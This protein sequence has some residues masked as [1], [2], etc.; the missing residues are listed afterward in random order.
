MANVWE[1]SPDG[2]TTKYDITDLQGRDDIDGINLLKYPF[3]ST[4][5][6]GDSSII[7]DNKNG[8][9]TF[10]GTTTQ[11]TYQGLN[12]RNRDVGL[13]LP[14]GKYKATGC[15]SGGGNNSYYMGLY[16]TKN[17]ASYALGIDYGEGVEITINGDDFSSEGAYVSTNFYV[18]SGNTV[19]FTWKP[20]ITEAKYADIPY[21]PYNQQSIQHQI[22][23]VTGVTG[24]RNRLNLSGLTTQTLNGVTCTVTRDSKGNVTEVDLNGTATANSDFTISSYTQ[25]LFEEGEW[26]LSDVNGYRTNTTPRTG[27]YTYIARK[28]G[29]SGTDNYIQPTYAGEKKPFTVNYSEY[30]Y[31][32][33]GIFVLKNTT[34]NHFKL[35][36]MVKS[37]SDPDDTYV[38]F[39]MTNRELTEVVE[40]KVLA[41]A[42]ANQTWASQ[43]A[44]LKAVWDTYS[45]VQKMRLCLLHEGYVIWYPNNTSVFGFN[46]YASDASGFDMYVVRAVG[47]SFM[48]LKYRYNLD[49]TFSCSDIT[50]NSDGA[51]LDLIMI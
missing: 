8:T 30:D 47:S 33:V 31:Y 10:N 15:P 4:N 42:A 48:L 5:V 16:C 32:F 45:Y 17:G 23:D 9:Y 27:A 50:Q 19:N 18:V 1:F 2:G 40:T 3:N 34:L 7:T 11:L 41:T 26:I 37:A 35:Y 20:M 22:N 21:R 43:L 51:R 6:S 39:A 13:F 44:T 14:N 28:K 46:G 36:P 29:A 49:G 24:V 12:G 25:Y 38:P